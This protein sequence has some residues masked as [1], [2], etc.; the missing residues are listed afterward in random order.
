[1]ITDLENILNL[2]FENWVKSVHPKIPDLKNYSHRLKLENVLEQHGFTWEEVAY[3][4]E[5]KIDPETPVTYQIKTK[6]GKTVKKTTTYKSASTRPKG[7]PARDAA[8]KLKGDGKSKDVEG[9]K[10]AGPGDFDRDSDSNKDIDPDYA[11]TTDDDK[12]LEIERTKELKRND[13]EKQ[14]TSD[15]DKQALEKFEKDLNDFYD[16]PTKA[17]AEELVEK[18]KLRRN[19]PSDPDANAKIYPGFLPNSA[20]HLYNTKSGA[21]SS[22]GGQLVR[23]LEKALGDK[24]PGEKKGAASPGQQLATSS[25]NNLGVPL[26]AKDS[27]VVREVFKDDNNP[28][29]DELTEGHKQLFGPKD[30]NGEILS[31]SDK[32]SREYLEH[33]INENDS[34]DNTIAK[35]KELEKT[36]NTSPKATKAMEEYKR[37]QQEI[38]KNYD[39]P[40][41]QA[42]QAFA[43]A[44]KDMVQVLAE[45]EPELASKLLKNMAEIAIYNIELARGDEV[46][47][48]SSPNFPGADKLVKTSEGIEGEIVTGVSVKFGK[49]GSLGIVGF[50]TENKQ[51]LLYHNDKSYRKNTS[52]VPGEE[53]YA[54]GLAD[55]VIDSDEAMGK[56][57]EE[58]GFGNVISDKKEYYGLLREYKEFRLEL[59]KEGYFG[60]SPTP[61]QKKRIR[62]KEDEFNAKFLAL[63]DKDE[64]SNVVGERNA[65][66]LLH[67]NPGAFLQGMNASAAC[68]SGGGIQGITSHSQVIENNEITLRTKGYPSDPK[69]LK[70]GTMRADEEARNGGLLIGTGHPS[71]EKT[72]DRTEVF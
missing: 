24:L 38:L 27:A 39:I 13:K 22:H 47:L 63:V 67:R 52:S 35:L 53:G 45:E 34:L 36:A 68:R 9:D 20:R 48:P 50:P 57:F 41:K 42:S 70:F 15:K 29:F 10:V 14:I 12:P 71:D 40:S 61:E 18:Y 64:L 28:A 7:T 3:L 11:R 49:D 54:V 62:E 4:M 26:K 60:K 21:A 19:F 46:Y 30:K 16:N 58:S 69:E 44:Y 55:E 8:D 37:K 1:M 2:I 65:K 25:K 32:H 31:P 33:A 43:D 66:S 5:A 6:D 17:K 72:T 51:I 56:L 23:D 59:Q